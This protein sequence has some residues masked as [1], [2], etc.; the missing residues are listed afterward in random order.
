MI[1][2]AVELTDELGL[3]ELVE[4]IIELILAELVAPGTKVDSGEVDG[5]N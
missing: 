3:G 1:G 2:E 4:I 5:S